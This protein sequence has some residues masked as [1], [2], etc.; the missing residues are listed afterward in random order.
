[1]ETVISDVRLALRSLRKHPGFTAVIILTLSLGIGANTAIFSFVNGLLLRPLPYYDAERLVRLTSQRGSEDG[2][3]SMIELKE[4]RDQLKSFESLGPYMPG[5][6]YNYSGDGPPEELSAVLVSRDFFTVLGVPQLHGQTWPADYD[7]ERNF[8]VV[9]SYDLWR[10]RFGSDPNVIGSKITLDAAPFYTIY[11]VMPAEFDFPA[12]MQIFRSI[13][14]N[15]RTP[16][17]TDRSARNVYALARLKPGVT[18]QQAQAELDGF[19]GRLAQGYPNINRGLTFNARPLRD[20]YVGNIRSYVWL[21][22]GAA[23]FVLLIA[24]TNVASLQLTRALAREREIAVRA[25]LGAS[26]LRVV[27]QLLTESLLV[28]SFGGMVGVVFAWGWIRLLGTLTQTQLPPWVKV[29]I[30]WRVLIFAFVVSIGAGLIAGLAPSVQASRPD[31]N[32]LLKEGAKGSSGGTRQRLRQALVIAE[33]AVALVLLVGA[34]LMVKSYLYLQRVDLG[35]N[36]DHLLTMRV[37][38]PWRKYSDETGIEREKLFYQQLLERL[39]TLPGVQSSALTNNLPLSAETDQGKTT[40]TREGQSAVEQQGNPYINDIRVSP[41]YLQTMGVRLLHGRFFNDSDTAKNERVGVVSRRL[42]ERVWPGQDPIG[43]R[44]KVGGV[45][46]QAHWTTIIGVVS[47]VRHEQIAGNG[48]LDLYI[49]YQQVPDA[50]MY[51]LLRT[52]VVPE[53]LTDAATRVVW[54]SDPE[55]S[56]FNI[57]AMDTRV[58][59]TIWQRRVSG[60]LVLIFA[61]LALVLAAIG[62]Y[63]VMSYVI[64]QRTRELGIRIAMGATRANVLLLVIASGARLIAIG[65]TIGLFVAFAVTRVMTSVLYG[66]S[67]FDPAVYGGVALLLAFV[68]VIACLIPA[69]R[70]TQVDPLTALRHE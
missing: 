32:E 6:Q 31:L 7:L 63:G 30:D 1:M 54:D 21:L 12:N 52:T 37:A 60:A 38:L 34:G 15:P 48:G 22:A 11:G 59:N 35:F 4:M 29:S 36:P 14:I 27:R 16:N 50:N 5:A 43:K 24:C 49:S 46:S 10:R 64:N 68:A 3:I 53:T 58:A 70:A 13:A 56:T 66:V 25:A 8:G 61:L 18:V 19:S 41:T 67:S 2:R 26:R 65:V 57:V 51:I 9:L 23:T 20:F 40:F 42:A 28:S 47:D 17:Y 33:V 69:K 55:Q 39:A 62:I 45:D 44:L